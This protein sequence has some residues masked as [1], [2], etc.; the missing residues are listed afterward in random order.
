MGKRGSKKIKLC[1]ILFAGIATLAIFVAR[2]VIA[3]PKFIWGPA[4]PWNNVEQREWEDHSFAELTADNQTIITEAKAGTMYRLFYLG[5]TDPGVVEATTYDVATGLTD[6]GGTQIDTYL[7]QGYGESE[8][9]HHQK[10]V[11]QVNGWWLITMYDPSTPDTFDSIIWHV[12]EIDDTNV[13][14]D[15]TEGDTYHKDHS[16]VET[17]HLQTDDDHHITTTEN[18]TL[19][20][21]ITGTLGLTPDPISGVP[22]PVTTSLLLLG[23]AAVAL[24]RKRI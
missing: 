24:R 2:S 15:M 7:Y 14:I 13:Y 4:H 5:N 21:N 19:T 11:N 17:S 10:D 8:I 9:I 3:A 16:D 12:D 18:G 1:S 23:V 22:E 6:L 20:M